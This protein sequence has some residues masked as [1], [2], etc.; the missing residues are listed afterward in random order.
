MRVRIRSKT[1]P[2]R[3]GPGGCLETCPRYPHPG[4]RLQQHRTTGVE[5]RHI[6]ELEYPAT[7]IESNPCTGS[8]PGSGFLE[9]LANGATI[10]R[11]RRSKLRLGRLWDEIPA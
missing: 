1:K 9:W 11:P 3:F 7:E 8:T 5:H 6:Q 10:A 4:V 2:T